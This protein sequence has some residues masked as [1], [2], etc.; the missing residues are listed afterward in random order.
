[1]RQTLAQ[2]FWSKVV[3][4]GE[5]DC[6]EWRAY[7]NKFGYGQIG[8]MRRKVAATHIA[9]LLD[10]RP[11]PEGFFALHSCDNPGCVNPHHLRWGTDRDNKADATLRGRWANGDRHNS[12]TR[13][14][15]IP[16]GSWH[17]STRNRQSI[18]KGQDH[19]QAKLSEKE[20]LAIRC[21][22][23]KLVPLAQKYGVS[24]S[25][26]SNIKRGKGWKHI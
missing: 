12:R 1:M 22:K 16:K 25:A 5:S 13:P 26:I 9:L 10:G 6:W 7:R 11:R 14:D 17:W 8:Y 19:H 4:R 23:E 3:I 24:I 21:S 18:Q 20:V 2:R 15:R